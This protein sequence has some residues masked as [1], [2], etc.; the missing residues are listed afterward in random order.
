MYSAKYFSKNVL[1]TSP[2]S[3]GTSDLPS[4]ST[5]PRS[6]IVL[7]IDAYVDGRPIPRF[8]SSFTSPASLY[9]PGGSVCFAC[10]ERSRSASA[11]PTAT[12]G[13]FTSS[14][15]PAGS[16]AIHPGNNTRDPLTEK[17]GI[18]PF[19]IFAMTLVRKI[20]ASLICDAMVLC[21]MSW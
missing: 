14:S 3:V 2:V 19:S 4:L 9:L 21:H 16:A 6:R 13:S 20:F 10:E 18:V 8:S 17:S 1:T 11:S 5:Y 12:F 15:R 7:M